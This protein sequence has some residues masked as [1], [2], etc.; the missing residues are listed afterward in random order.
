LHARFTK[1]D[2]DNDLYT[3]RLA[4]DDRSNPILPIE[5][6]E[7]VPR[8]DLIVLEAKVFPGINLVWLG[9]VLMMIGFFLALLNKLK[10]R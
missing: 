7:N 10:A 2:P 3:V 5:I 9:M 8:S 4:K 1:I 6:A